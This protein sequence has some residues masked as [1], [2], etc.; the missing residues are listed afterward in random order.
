MW[1]CIRCMESDE[2]GLLSLSIS[3]VA[4]VELKVVKTSN[5]RCFSV[6]E[7]QPAAKAKNKINLSDMFNHNN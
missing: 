4:W 2:G 1:K 7:S 6:P 3:S 5:K